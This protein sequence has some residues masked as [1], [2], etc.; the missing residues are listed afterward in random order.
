MTDV[1]EIV[2]R[3]M[4]ALRPEGPT[5]TRTS[6]R[7]ILTEAKEGWYEQGRVVGIE[8]ERK[9]VRVVIDEA[10]AQAV[11]A[12]REEKE[13]W[14]QLAEARDKVLVAYRMGGRRTPEKALDDIADA[15]ARLAAIRQEVSDGNL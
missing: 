6:F 4:D 2:E 10:I 9:N 1:D 5:R 11:Q 7:A 3:L 13:A 12:E 8:S 15:K 14:K